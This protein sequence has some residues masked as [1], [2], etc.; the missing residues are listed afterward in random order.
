MVVC[1]YCGTETILLEAGVPTCVTCC[2]LPQEARQERMRRREAT[3]EKQSSS[4]TGK[5]TRSQAG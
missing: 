4:G 1:V 5:D 3:Q 2:D